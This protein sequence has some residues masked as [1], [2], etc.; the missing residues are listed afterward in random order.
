MV[1]NEAIQLTKELSVS[2]I[3]PG[4]AQSVLKNK[5]GIE[6]SRRQVTTLLP[7]SQVCQALE[8]VDLLEKAVGMSDL[9]RILYSLKKSGGSYTMLLHKREGA[10]GELPKGVLCTEDHNDTT[11]AL[12]AVGADLRQYALV[13]CLNSLSLGIFLLS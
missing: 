5:F 8:D 6:L 1:S 11:T 3:R 7:L 13:S 12:D 10:D 9:D 2:G 4:L